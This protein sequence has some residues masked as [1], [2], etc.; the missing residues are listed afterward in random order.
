VQ[1]AGI[2]DGGDTPI[3]EFAAGKIP[4]LDVGMG[5]QGGATHGRATKRSEVDLGLRHRRS[6]DRVVDGQSTP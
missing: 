1:T 2:L 5:C 3:L 6:S 4:T